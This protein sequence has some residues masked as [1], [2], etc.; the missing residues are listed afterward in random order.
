MLCPVPYQGC[1]HQL[2]WRL[3]DSTADYELM[4]VC[5]LEGELCFSVKASTSY[6]EAC[7]ESC[8]VCIA[9]KSFCAHKYRQAYLQSKAAWLASMAILCKIG[10]IL[11]VLLYLAA[12]DAC[13]DQ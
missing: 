10:L 3:T 9:L 11:T 13:G 6:N 12:A 4:I 5:G 1:Q 2:C 8:F 7:M